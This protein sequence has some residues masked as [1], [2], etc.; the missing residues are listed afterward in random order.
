MEDTSINTRLE[1]KGQK[2]PLVRDTIHNIA[3]CT[4]CYVGIPFDWLIAHMYDNHGLKYTSQELLQHM[5]VQEPTMKAMEASNWLKANRAIYQPIT[6]VPVQSGYSCSACVYPAKTKK[7]IYNHI[8][9]YH[10]GDEERATITIIERSIQKPFFSHL[11]QY[12]QVDNEEDR[13]R[14]EDV[15]GWKS[16]L[17][18]E[19]NEMLVR[20]SEREGSRNVDLRLVNVFIAK[21]RF[22]ILLSIANY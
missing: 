3:V 13:E 4:D 2:L 9:E 20:L 6:K 8:S 14:E 16:K 11:K 17:E 18:K 22:V 21:I 12:I 1:N 7:A 19:Y 15:P 10:K 5:E